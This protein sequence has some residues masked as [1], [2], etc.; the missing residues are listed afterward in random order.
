MLVIVFILLMA[1]KAVPEGMEYTVERY[2]RF[3]KILKPGFNVI[4]PFI[5]RVSYKVDMR[6]RKV[7]IQF[8][9]LKTK[10]NQEIVTSGDLH[11]QVVDAHKVAYDRGN[12]DENIRLRAGLEMKKLVKSMTLDEVMA[13]ADVLDAAIMES[14]E[15]LQYEWGI[16]VNYIDVHKVYPA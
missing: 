11:V 7:P 15:P 3:T 9:D 13:E 12:V 1:I 5:D 6:E 10:D 2:G 16:K 8:G 14:V 4:L